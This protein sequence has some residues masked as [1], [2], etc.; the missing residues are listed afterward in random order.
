[1]KT[2]EQIVL[3]PVLTEKSIRLKEEGRY[4]FFVHKDANKLEIARAIE[5]IYNR[6][7]KKEKDKIKVV[8]VNVINVK[9]KTVQRGR[10]P[11]GKR[12]DRKKAIITLAPGQFLED[13]GA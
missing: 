4:V 13:I 12:P 10:Q 1:M 8:D 11:A 2:P 9:G 6:G 7:K 5:A 3:A